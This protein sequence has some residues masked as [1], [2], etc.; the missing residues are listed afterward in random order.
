M[1]SINNQILQDS[2]SRRVK[3]GWY[4]F[5]FANSFLIINGGLY[6]PQ[7]VI[8]DLELSDFWFNLC[9]TLSS[10]L[11]FLTAPFLGALADK[12]T[13]RPTTFLRVTSS[14]MFLSGIAI[15][16]GGRILQDRQVMAVV[17]LISFGLIM[18]CYNVSLT[19][20]NS[21][22]GRISV[23]SL[24][25]RT[26]GKGMAFGW[27]GGIV[28]IL[29]IL[30]FVEGYVPGF[31]PAGRIQAILPATLLY[32]VLTAV[33]LMLLGNVAVESRPDAHVQTIGVLRAL[34][35]GLRDIFSRRILWLYLLGYFLFAD[36]ILTLQNNSP[37]Y[38]EVVMG[39]DDTEKAMIFVLLLVMAAI[40]GVLSGRIAERIGLKRTL[41]GT[42]M[43]WVVVMLSVS[44]TRNLIFLVVLFGFVGLLFGSVWSVSRAFYLTA[45]Q[46]SRTG[47]YFGL[48]SS[49]ERCA[50]IIGPLIWSATVALLA[51]QGASR[52]RIAVVVLA[53][54]VLLSI[55]VI[56]KVIEPEIQEHN[57]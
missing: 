26:S 42:L 47:V 20:Y 12:E 32:G 45:I 48:Y 24:Y 30:P 55:F 2:R 56:R 15:G 18:Y 35:S 51:N 37:I 17:S 6:F 19:F 8:I 38:L 14:V 4:L 21:L 29:V 54:L 9:I 5:D 57:F 27:L 49:Y 25:A 43:G 53:F 46:R 40:G 50:T 11:L 23:P 7:W 41:L 31:Q 34:K 3:A 22:L 16:L 39:L 10:V 36:A 44:I 1:K 28:G 33:S 13:S 52:Y